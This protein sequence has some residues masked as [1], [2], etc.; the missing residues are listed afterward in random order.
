MAQVHL[1][2]GTGHLEHGD[3]PEALKELLSAETYDSNDPLIQNNLGLTYYMREKYD[4][5]E[6]HIRKAIKLEPTFTDAKNNLSRVLIEK[7]N[8]KE[9]KVI[10]K[11]VI[12]DLTYSVT[13]KAYIN[14]G[15]AQFKEND[16][17]AAKESFLKALAIDRENCLAQNYYARS[18][19]EI[20]DFKHASNAFEK[21]ET[22]CLKSQF[23]DPI[24]YSALNFYRMGDPYKAKLKFE[25]LIDKGSTFKEKAEQMLEL[26]RK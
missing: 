4:L 25:A 19:M 21:A 14:L 22:Y 5:A 15:L 24:F 1:R 16:F 9:A 6:S 13:W 17:A 10:L 7:N 26:L 12:D 3:Y 20:K 23:D 11:E 2:L 18:L 8:T